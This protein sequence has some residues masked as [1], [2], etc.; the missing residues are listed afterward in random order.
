[1]DDRRTPAPFGR[2]AT[3]TAVGL[4][5]LLVSMPFADLRFHGLLRE[6]AGPGPTVRWNVDDAWTA[7][8]VAVVAGV[9][10]LAVVL[11][12]PTVLSWALLP[13]AVV[14]GWV[15]LI[16]CDIQFG[17]RFL[18]DEVG[19]RVNRDRSLAPGGWLRLVGMLVVVAGLAV[20]LLERRRLGK[21][22][23][24]AHSG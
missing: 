19:W 21:G 8:F 9:L 23:F 7:L 3:V 5:L 16:Y 17:T 10:A 14:V 24:D 12:R 1:M 2:A 6:L 11:R 15:V 22:S 18:V 4:V 13:A 20:A